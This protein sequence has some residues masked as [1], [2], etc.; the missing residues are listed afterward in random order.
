MSSLRLTT[1][2][3]SENPDLHDLML[4]NGQIQWIG[5]D[6]SDQDE[7]RSMV[8]QRLDTSIRHIKG[9][10]FMDLLKGFPYFDEI[11]VKNPTI[12]KVRSLLRRYCEQVPGISNVEI[13]DISVETSTRTMT[14]SGLIIRTEAGFVLTYQQL[15]IPW[16][17][18]KKEVN[19]D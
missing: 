8:R 7:S 14:I 17:V 12:K 16:L 1:E 13:G 18:L 9:E 15:D 11:F 6:T 2:T 19:R 5:F 4:I 10:F 3:D